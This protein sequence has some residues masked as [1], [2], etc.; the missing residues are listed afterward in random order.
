VAAGS[1][2]PFIEKAGARIPAGLVTLFFVPNIGGVTGTCYLLL[3]YFV[4]ARDVMAAMA[5][6]EHER[7]ERSLLN[8]LPASIAERLKGGE[9]VIADRVLEVGVLFARSAGRST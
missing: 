5:E 6:Q 4:R 8:V 7:S 1:L 2:D 9:S 3:H